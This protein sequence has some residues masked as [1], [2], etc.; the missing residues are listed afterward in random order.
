MGGTV[1]MKAS[2]TVS[3]NR[4]V[5]ITADR[6]VTQCSA[7]DR[8]DGI[9]QA[10]V[11]SGREVPVALCDGTSIIPV[12]VGTGGATAGSFAKVVSD[13]VADAGLIGG[14]TTAF[15]VFGPFFEGGVAGDIVGIVSR[16]FTTVSA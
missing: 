1:S 3:E 16:S 15:N 7:G 6:T 4:P 12:L 13:G 5:K 14:G 10:T 2:G 8:V 11:A 9:A